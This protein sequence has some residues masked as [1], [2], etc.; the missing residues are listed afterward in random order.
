VF[1]CL[2]TTVDRHACEK[3][4]SPG[5]QKGRARGKDS[6]WRVEQSLP[7]HHGKDRLGHEGK[8]GMQR[9]AT[10]AGDKE[11]P[12]CRY[13]A[14]HDA[15]YNPCCPRALTAIPC[16]APLGSPP[17]PTII[18]GA[19]HTYLLSTAI[20][21]APLPPRLLGR[22]ALPISLAKA[23]TT[24]W[25]P[26]P[27]H[28]ARGDALRPWAAAD[29]Q[30]QLLFMCYIRSTATTAIPHAG[31]VLSITLPTPRGTHTSRAAP[32]PHH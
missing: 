13:T 9:T 25:R 12:A 19:P 21:R 17:T 4:A 5:R 8:T 15:S 32:P 30:P 22:T 29:G 31:P 3:P 20:T 23:A 11:P 26:L 7:K 18:P 28:G 2:W 27:F 10:A 14:A 24:R 1:P 6:L 16:F